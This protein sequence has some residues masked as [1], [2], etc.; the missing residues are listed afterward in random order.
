MTERASIK[1]ALESMLFVWGEPLDAK[2]AA[3]VFG[4]EEAVITE[5]LKELKAAYE[6]RE[7][8]ILIQRFGDCFQLCTAE[9][10]REYIE[11]LC[12][13]AREKKLSRS[14]LEVL[15]IIAYRQ[16]VTRGE[17]ESIRGVRCSYVLEGLTQ[18]GLIE[19]TGRSEAVGQPI[20]Y[21]TTDLFLR[22][23]GIED[24]NELPD[25]EDEAFMD[26]PAS[27]DG[28]IQSE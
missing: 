22:H 15:A 2:T 8:G 1:S 17:I 25:L 13:P 23:F 16:P 11:R 28:G 18:K 26:P 12:N 10:N 5:C 14:A 6:E 24:L 4:E 27:L 19:E 9:G 7:G 3:Q 21:G 20:L